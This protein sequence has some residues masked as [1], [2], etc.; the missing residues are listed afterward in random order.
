LAEVP[1]RARR[2]ADFGL[3]NVFSQGF[4][5]ADFGLRNV[6]SQGFRIADFGLRIGDWFFPMGI[7][8]RISDRSTEQIF[9]GAPFTF[10]F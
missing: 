9:L 6:F 5:I 2:I 10:F 8:L 1:V 4:R 3:R 7:G